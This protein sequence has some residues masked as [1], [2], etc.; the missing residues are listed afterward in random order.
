MD[1]LGNVLVEPAFGA[2]AIRMAEL[3]R[4]IIA[5][6]KFD[7]DV[8]GHYARPDVFQL[9][10]NTNVLKSV[11]FSAVSPAASE[12]SPRKDNALMVTDTMP[13]PS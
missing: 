12:S 4:R 13:P 11:V 8:V 6:A 9:S 3:D 2:E 7:L 1:P 10:V 5:R